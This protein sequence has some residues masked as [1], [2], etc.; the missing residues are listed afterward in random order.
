MIRSLY[1]QAQRVLL[2]LLSVVSFW[3][4]QPS[5]TGSGPHLSAQLI[6]DQESLSPGS[7]FTLGVKFTL[8]PGWH[9]YWKNPGDSGLPPRFSWSTNPALT[10]SSPLWPYPER[11]VTGPLVNYGYGDV[12]I[13]F[14]AK[15]SADARGSSTII[16]LGLQWLV[17]KDEC[18]PGEA[19]VA[20][21]L[22]ISTQA[23]A[24]SK[25][26]KEFEDAMGRV[27]VPLER[28]SIAVEE[29][30]DQLIMA[31]IPLDGRA[32]PPRFTFFPDDKRIISNNKE[33]QIER[34]GDSVRIT[35][36]RDA[37][38]QDS[39][40]RIRGVLV[41]PAGWG[42]GGGPKAVSIDTNPSAP[43]PSDL[44]GVAHA[45]AK[46]T[47]ASGTLGFLSIIIFALI[48]GLLLNIMPCVFPV[49]SIKIL[50]FVEQSGNDPKSTRQ[51]GLMFSLGV[52]VSFWIVAALLLTVRVGG[53]Q[54][55]WGFQL[56]SPTFVVV[57][58]VVFLSLGLLFITDISLG[59]RVQNI[60]GRLHI[61]T[62]LLGSFL[63]GALATAVA[64]PCT[65]PYMSTALAATLTLPALLSLCVFTAIGLGMSAPY[66][67]LSYRPELLR[68][69][70]KPGE[71]M[72]TFKE[73]MAF[74][75]FA[76]VV[77]LARVFARQ[78]GL[79]PPGLDVVVNVLWGLLSISFAFWLW[80]RSG[81]SPRPRV[82]QAFT[83]G[84]LGM[85]VLGVYMALPQTED[86]EE[87]RA[88]ACTPSGTVIPFTDSYGLL[89]E[90]FSEERLVKVLA[91]G[92]PVFLDF[93]AEWCITCQVNEKIV[94]SSEEV[95]DLIV[96]KN[97][98]LM[99][100]DWTS[101][102]PMITAALRRYGRNGVPL[103]VIL[104]SPS[105]EPVL[106]P[107]ILTPAI[108]LD[109]LKQLP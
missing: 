104:A 32:L 50:S 66:L 38:N 26:Y 89:W 54:L 69:L 11:L 83:A 61:P 20:L 31:L 22:P 43:P 95:R 35:L 18:L 77:W 73:L 51:H 93:T 28:V 102:N 101:K 56:Q 86:V 1:R 74:P 48:G 21:S 82:A 40:T 14:P 75:L 97:V 6:S 15:L 68:F 45:E 80:G 19:T 55:G 62:S 106:L 41:A 103:N 105:A 100:A 7:T 24:P 13:P 33:Q 2:V 60:A 10:V 72:V 47:S 92:R 25:H 96:R 4:C 12:L 5:D 87:S 34:D 57:M 90:S 49:L 65:A 70:P 78:M 42:A 58:M 84:A 16:T 108:V 67:L 91:Q 46:A 94:F 109:A 76:S 79:E 39:I 53:E 27:P 59:Q 107:N 30:P 63:N 23:S 29:R 37:L 8:E 88:R 64:T 3:G 44:L 36:A 71:W 99:R 85:F 98:T 9:I 17:C 52:L 81:K